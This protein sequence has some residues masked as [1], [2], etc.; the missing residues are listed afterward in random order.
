MIEIDGSKGEG[1]GQII[2][3]AIALSAVTGTPVRI[4]NIRVNRPNPGLSH[5]HLR[6]AEFLAKITDAEVQGLK[7]GSKE[8]FF[9]P[10]RIKG[11]DFDVDIKTAGSISLFLQSLIPAA[12]YASDRLR[13]RVRGGTDVKWSPPIDFLRFILIPA[14]REMGAE[15][16]IELLRRGYYPKGGGLVQVEIEPSALSGFTPPK[17]GVDLVKGISHASNLPGHVVRRQAESAE[18]KLL[19]LGIRSEITLE[20]VSEISTGSGIFLYS[21]YKSGSALGER[22]KPAE[23]VG[24]EAADSLITELN[25]ESTVDIYLADQLIPFMALADGRSEITV[26]EISLHLETNIRV[27]EAFLQ[28]TFRVERTNGAVKVLKP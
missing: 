2:R 18:K 14:L 28:R 15:I 21:G 11:G 13:V 9:A 24:L 22:G 7:L 25:A 8:L 1:G 12:L 20:Q 3:T 6:G 10:R 5:Q 4:T 17:L 16:R 19:D 23:S 26:R 27:V